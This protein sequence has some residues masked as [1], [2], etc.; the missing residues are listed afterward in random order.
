MLKRTLSAVSLGLAMLSQTV[1]ASPDERAAALLDSGLAYLAA[2]Q[3]DDGTWQPVEQVPPAITAL[4]LR[5]FV[6]SEVY[7]PDDEIV[8]RGYEALIAQQVA[9]G[10][11]YE[12]LL[13]NY[14]TAIAVSAI[15]EAR[16]EAGDDRYADEMSKAV[17][18]LRKLQWVPGTEPE[19]EGDE[20]V[21]RVQ[22][23]DDPFLGGWG[24]GGRSRGAGRPDLSNAQMALEALHAAGIPKD[25]AAYQRAIQFITRLQNNSETNSEPWASD[26][27]VFIYGPDA[28]RSF[29][30]FAGEYTTPDGQR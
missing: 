15:A 19:F 9:D 28:D 25:D 20:I 27:G 2:Q 11:I 3:Q 13:A 4:A 12:D 21:Q 14:N 10:G 6:G 23:E 1:A 26:D 30:S 17:A 7:T 5:G 8:R 24:Y 22:G 16:K 29:E 18:Y